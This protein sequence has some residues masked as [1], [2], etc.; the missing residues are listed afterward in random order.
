[1]ASIKVIG[2]LYL[3]KPFLEAIGVREVVDQIVPMQ[4][5][6]DDLTHGEVL[7]QLVINRLDAP[8]SPVK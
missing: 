3:L 4:R 2:S 6:V 1:V 8:C 5:D 7:E